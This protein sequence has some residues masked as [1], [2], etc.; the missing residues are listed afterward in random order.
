MTQ[1]KIRRH[2]FSSTDTTKLTL[3]ASLNSKGTAAMVQFI[4]SRVVYT[5]NVVV[6]LSKRSN[7][8]TI[9]TCRTMDAR[10]FQTARKSVAAMV[11]AL[12]CFVLISGCGM[13]NQDPT[14]GKLFYSKCLQA[15][16]HSSIAPR[17]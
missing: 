13:E 7:V 15:S 2:L 11:L 10:F 1:K 16:R 3:S 5:S 17:D 8:Y 12:I 14:D 6:A 9:D 4:L